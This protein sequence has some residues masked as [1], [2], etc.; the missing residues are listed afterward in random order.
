M[1][2]VIKPWGSYEDHYRR[3]DV[4]FKVLEISPGQAISYQ[5]H[6][7]RSEFWFIQS[8][9]GLFKFSPDLSPM[10][11]YSVAEVEAG[12]SIEINA[13][14]AHQITNIGDSPLIIYEMQ[15]GKCDEKDITRLDDPYKR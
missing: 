4:V 6:K 7:D 12:R 3:D 8:G 15:F 13:G 9:K 14:M 10:T 2:I 1:A 5:T 11:N